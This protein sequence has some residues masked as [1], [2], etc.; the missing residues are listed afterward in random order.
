METLQNIA[1]YCFLFVGLYFQV[2]ILVVYTVNRRKIRDDRAKAERE[3]ALYPSVTIIVPCYNEAKTVGKTVESL[4]ALKYPAGKLRI[5]AV[6]DGSRDNTWSVLQNLQSRYAMLEIHRKENGGKYTALNYA[7]EHASTDIVGCLDADSLV[8]SDAL[9]KMV[10]FFGDLSAPLGTPGAMVAAVTPGMKIYKP[11]TLIQVLQYTEYLVGMLVKKVQA[12]IGAIYVTPGPFSLFR[13]DLFA[14]IGYFQH[15]HNT[16]DMELAFRIQASHLHIE[17]VH[18][19]IVYTAGPATIAK[20]Y[21]QRVRWTSGFLLNVRDYRHMLLNPRYGNLALFTVPIGV[22]M[23]IG[24][25][26]S[27]A[28]IIYRFILS[29]WHFSVQMRVVG[30]QAPHF[31]WNWFFVSTQAH[32]LLIAVV[33]FLMIGMIIEARILAGEKTLF[34]RSTVLYFILFP[35]LS[36]WWIIKSVYNAAISHAPSWQKERAVVTVKNSNSPSL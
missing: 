12:C 7:I 25:V 36:P 9:K 13:R 29:L 34:G 33:Y 21:R 22:A 28:F 32:F 16:E 1:L 23:I 20:L 2:F 24:V 27:V 19:A 6:D 14:K 31:A 4:A 3:P 10:P 15:A 8:A 35:L 18:D 30:W 26:S 11:K 5:V 17:N